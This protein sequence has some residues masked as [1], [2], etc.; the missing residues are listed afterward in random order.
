MHAKVGLYF[1][2]Q[3]PGEVWKYL[4]T[5]CYKQHNFRKLAADSAFFYI[6]ALHEA[7]CFLEELGNLTWVLI[8]IYEEVWNPPCQQW[9]FFRRS[10]DCV[11]LFKASSLEL[12]RS[13]KK[14]N[15][16]L[17]GLHMM[18]VSICCISSSA[19]PLHRDGDTGIYC[20]TASVCVCFWSMIL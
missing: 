12:S 5:C 14:W 3:E 8:V 1:R 7:N 13:S 17:L 19:R 10:Q 4:N 16:A 18:D 20:T 15:I 2:V 11:T 9:W 6:R